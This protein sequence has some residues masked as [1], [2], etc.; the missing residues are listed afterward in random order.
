MVFFKLTLAALALI[1]APTPKTTA[2]IDVPVFEATVLSYFDD[3]DPRC[4]L[5]VISAQDDGDVFRVT[6][7]P[8]CELNG[9]PVV[10]LE[11][12]PQ[13]DGSYRETV[14]GMRGTPQAPYWE[15][16]AYSD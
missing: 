12:A 7:V 9:Y 5:A 16:W 6:A 15:E 11:Y 3:A 4:T 2:V 1:A 8:R 10:R 13:P 14:Y